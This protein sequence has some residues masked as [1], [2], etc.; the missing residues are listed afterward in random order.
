MNTL[1]ILPADIPVPQRPC[2]LGRRASNLI[3]ISKT[4]FEY[5]RERHFRGRFAICNRN[6]GTLRVAS[7]LAKAL[8]RS[9]TTIVLSIAQE[10]RN[11]TSPDGATWRTVQLKSAYRTEDDNL[12]V[13]EI[14]P[15]ED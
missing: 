14:A 3:P 4:N 1:E 13:I 10:P 9:D 2:Q 6:T 5:M 7:R 15:K 8:D 11:T 12:C